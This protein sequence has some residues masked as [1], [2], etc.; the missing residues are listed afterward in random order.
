MLDEPGTIVEPDV[1]KALL[2]YFKDMKMLEGAYL[3][4]NTKMRET[5]QPQQNSAAMRINKTKLR[6][7]I[8]ETVQNGKSV[9]S[10]YRAV[11]EAAMSSVK[12][13]VNK[14]NDGSFEVSILDGRFVLGYHIDPILVDEGPTK[15][16]MA[17]N[18]DNDEDAALFS[19]S[20][21]ANDWASSRLT[22][23]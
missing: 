12:P 7:I 13:T 17:K 19:T 2:K 3:S 23:N 11:R 22:S 14:Y 5:T 20:Q 1:R 16:Y 15:F 9:R 21:K 6:R 10:Q 8:R 18:F 4:K